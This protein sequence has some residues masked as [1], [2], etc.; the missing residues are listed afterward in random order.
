MDSPKLGTDVLYTLNEGDIETI[1]Q[2]VPRIN[3]AAGQNLNQPTAG[4]QYPAKVVRCWPNSSAANLKVF[5]DGGATAELWAT[6]RVE[7]TGPG[8]WQRP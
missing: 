2:L 4:E 6:S 8:T 1:R 5:L 7:G 3:S